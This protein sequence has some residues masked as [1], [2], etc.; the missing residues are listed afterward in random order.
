MDRD[1]SW[2]SL[3]RSTTA[4]KSR[5]QPNIALNRSVSTSS[6]RADRDFVIKARINATSHGGWDK[7]EEDEPSIVLLAAHT[8]PICRQR[9]SPRRGLNWH[10]SKGE[11][12][13]PIPNP[14]T[15]TQEQG[16]RHARLLNMLLRMK[17]SKKVCSR[18]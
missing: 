12:G 11:N 3:E 1:V 5:N 15:P 10:I 16:I 9:Q 2:P 18:L 4:S 6:T 14:T 17:E 8:A 7:T 13:Q